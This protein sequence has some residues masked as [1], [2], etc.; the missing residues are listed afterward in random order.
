[1]QIGQFV[2]RGPSV[3][4][5]HGTPIT[6]REQ[7]LRMAGRHFCVSY[8]ADQD[9]KTC[10]RIGQS[11]MFDNGAFSVWT[12]GGALDVPGYYR[13]LEP[14]LAPPHFAIIPDVI[15]G[16]VEQNAVLVEDWPRRWDHVGAP[17]W[18]LNEPLDV[19]IGFIDNNWQRVCFGSAGESSAHR[20]GAP[21]WMKPSTR[22]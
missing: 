9:L 5:Y 10:L 2:N 15:D 18:H 21:A 6:P 3:I 16:T 20:R 7:L 12:K 14:V 13:W 19:L 22:W 17:V 1:V 8:A 11:V 4:H